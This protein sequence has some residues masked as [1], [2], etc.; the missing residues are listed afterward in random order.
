M[1]K[2]LLTCV[3]GELMPQTIKY[4]K[5]IKDTKLTI[6]GTDIYEDAIGK[7]FCDKF[8]KVPRGNCED[9]IEKCKQI[10]KKE[11]INLII[12]TSDEEALNLSRNKDYFEKRKVTIAC[13]DFETLQTL[14]NKSKTYSKLNKCGIKTAEWALIK[15]EDFLKEKLKLYIKKYGG[16]VIKPC[17]DRGSRNIFIISKK[18]RDKIDNE[19]IHFFKNINQ[20][21]N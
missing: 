14:N 21:C 12:P 8:Y 15:N 1:I 19:N 13:I 4:F 17:S 11:K 3:G 7:Y 16:A 9:F 5:N 20:S 6:I 2:I 10:V 18:K